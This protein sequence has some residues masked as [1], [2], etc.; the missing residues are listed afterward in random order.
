ML[1][2]GSVEVRISQSAGTCIAV[3]PVMSENQVRMSRYCEC[4]G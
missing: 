3:H 1:M 4:E 2:L